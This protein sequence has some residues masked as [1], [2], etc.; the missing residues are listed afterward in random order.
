MLKQVPDQRSIAGQRLQALVLQKTPQALDQVLTL[1]R[2]RQAQRQRRQMTSGA[3][4]QSLAQ[5]RQ[6]GPLRLAGTDAD[7]GQRLHKL[8]M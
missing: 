1:T 2:K 5:T 6:V 4:R 8:S 7:R 3:E